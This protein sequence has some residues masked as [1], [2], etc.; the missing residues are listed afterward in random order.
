MLETTLL[1]SFV[2]GLVGGGIIWDIK[3]ILGP[4]YLQAL[5][6]ERKRTPQ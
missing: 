3:T 2:A 6:T 5:I 4:E 1:V